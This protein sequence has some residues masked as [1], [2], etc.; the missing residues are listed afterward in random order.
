M[1]ASH[2]IFDPLCPK[3]IG[4]QIRYKGGECTMKRPQLVAKIKPWNLIH[5][6]TWV[7][8]T[9]CC[10]DI[11]HP[12]CHWYGIQV[13][14]QESRWWGTT[15]IHIHWGQWASEPTPTRSKKIVGPKIW[16]IYCSSASILTLV[17]PRGGT[18]SNVCA[19]GVDSCLDHQCMIRINSQKRLDW[20]LSKPCPASAWE[21]PWLGQL[22]I[23]KFTCF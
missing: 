19:R 6:G 7:E 18:L 10:H 8:R 4:V 16:Q 21:W 2:T 5:L 13:K 1:F 11:I 17:S 20:G 23:N 22:A 15:T 9:S 12:A 14:V 3:C